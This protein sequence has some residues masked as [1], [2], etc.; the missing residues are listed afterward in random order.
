MFGAGFFE[1]GDVAGD[2]GDF[3]AQSTKLLQIGAEDFHGDLRRDTAEHVADAVGERRTHGTEGPRDATHRG[4][5]FLDDL[6]PVFFAVFV[7]LDLHFDGGDR[8]DV[9][10]AFG[11]S[12][13]VADFLDP[14]DPE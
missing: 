2:V 1:T 3:G 4:A 6:L 8:H 9:V 14:L 12:G 7:E 5:D 13:A 11:A 10:P